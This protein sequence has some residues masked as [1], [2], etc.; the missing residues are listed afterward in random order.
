MKSNR[1]ARGALAVMPVLLSGLF[2]PLN[3]TTAVLASVVL[4]C[5]LAGVS[6]LN[7]R[8]QDVNL[9]KVKS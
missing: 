8:R 4:A 1:E 9:A 6:M 5:A 7:S 2:L 3:G